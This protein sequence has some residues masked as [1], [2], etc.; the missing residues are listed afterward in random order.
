M[1]PYGD[2]IYVSDQDLIRRILTVDAPKFATGE[3]NRAIDFLVGPCS[4]LL[5]DG[6]AHKRLRNRLSHL[7]Q[8][9]S[10][11]DQELLTR[12]IVIAEMRTWQPGHTFALL[13]RLQD[14]SLE[15][16]LR[17]VFGFDEGTHLDRLRLLVPE[18][19]A[20]SPLLIL[21]PSARQHMRRLGFWS[22][23]FAR[24]DETDEILLSKIAERRRTAL[25]GATD[26]LSL[27]ITKTSLNDNEIR[28]NLVT[29]LAVGHET[30]S[31]ASTWFFE[32][33]LRHPEIHQRIVAELPG[34]GALLDA[35]LYEAL[36]TRPVTM[37]IGRI[38]KTPIQY[39]G[40]DFAPGTLFALSLAG[41][42][43]SPQSFAE[44]DEFRPDR[45][46]EGQVTP[47]SFLPFGGGRHRCLGANLALTELRAIASTILGNCQLQAIGDAEKPRPRGPMIVPHRGGR[48]RVVSNVFHNT[49]TSQKVG[50]Q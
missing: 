4:L 46:V 48:I 36:R 47:G 17:A 7:F 50:V 13:P 10:L 12:E 22:Q 21:F 2:V 18:L 29:L 33:V 25:P 26:A 34:G 45:F 11:R 28:D 1:F 19:L 44:P 23:H 40:F 38:V 14:I 32:R 39:N 6:D 30:T 35:A 42:H 37:D 49:T 27:L 15:I 3:A 31:V 8:G 5:L 24:H 41:L 43:S 9:R 16:M 20:L